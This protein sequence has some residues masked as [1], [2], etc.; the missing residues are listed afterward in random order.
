VYYS[1]EGKKLAYDLVNLRMR[2]GA[3]L[4]ISFITGDNNFNKTTILCLQKLYHTFGTLK[5]KKTV[6]PLARFA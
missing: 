3:R 6:N 5:I 1:S 2:L 4:K